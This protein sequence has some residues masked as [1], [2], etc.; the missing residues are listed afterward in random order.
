[1]EEQIPEFARKNGIAQFST[2]PGKPG[3]GEVFRKIRVPGPGAGAYY[4]ASDDDYT[5][6]GLA[7]RQN[8]FYYGIQVRPGWYNFTQL[9]WRFIADKVAKQEAFRKQ[10]IDVTGVDQDE[11]EHQL[12]ND[13]IINRVA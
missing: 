6:D 11:W 8:P 2:E 5:K 10:E 9:R 3:F 7:L 1:Y 4:L 12:K 13:E